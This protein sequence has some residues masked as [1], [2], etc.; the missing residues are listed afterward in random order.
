MS[1]EDD[2]LKPV[3]GGH[4]GIE[5]VEEF[6]DRALWEAKSTIH[7]SERALVELI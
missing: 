6:I 3:I 1:A 4:L 5:S 2:L 7:L